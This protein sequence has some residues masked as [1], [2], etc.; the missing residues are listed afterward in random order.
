MIYQA[1]WRPCSPVCCF[2]VARTREQVF[3]AWNLVYR[4]YRQ[5][6]L[7]PENRAQVHAAPQM[8]SDAASVF[9]KHQYN[10]VHATLS[11]LDDSK[12]GLPLDTVYRAELDALRRQGRR[13]TEL[14]HLADADQSGLLP[15]APRHAYVANRGT[16]RPPRKM[17]RRAR[18]AELE[19]LMGLAVGCGIEHGCDDLVIGVH[20]RHT[21]F[22]VRAWGFRALGEET[23]Y[24][25]VCNLPVQLMRLDWRR[26]LDGPHGVPM[27]RRCVA[28]LP[29]KDYFAGRWLIRPTAIASQPHATINQPTRA[30]EPAPAGQPAPT[31]QP[32]RRATRNEN[33]RRPIASAA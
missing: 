9:I 29:G 26:E 1:D 32:P 21:R 7:I 6:G 11:S 19:A 23:S 27:L 18:L 5:A 3:S 33:A 24:P 15:D 12:R 4:V 20:P 10:H 16:Y 28:N 31:G 22:Y 13:L 25:T 2:D 30:S 14:A 8:F 17:D